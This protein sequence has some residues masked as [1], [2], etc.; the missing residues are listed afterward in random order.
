M[1]LPRPIRDA[2]RP[3]VGRIRVPI[4]SGVNRGRWWSLASAGNGYALGTRDARQMEFFAGLIRPGDCVWDVGAHHG[5]M[6][7]CADRAAGPEGRVYAFEP[8]AR[9]AATLRRHLR[10][11]D[12][13]K[14]MA[15]NIA[16]SD[17]EGTTLFG[18]TGTSKMFAMGGGSETVQV[19]RGAT[20]IEDGRCQ[21]PTVMKIDVEG[22]EAAVLRG[23]GDH[24]PPNARLVVAIHS[25]A[26]FRECCAVLAARG[27][28]VLI[29]PALVECVSGDWD[30]DP[31]LLAL[32]PSSGMSESDPL[33]AG[34]AAG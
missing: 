31:D 8:S 28:H 9:N 15:L 30:G 29:S 18:G 19:T 16:L 4:L 5:Y 27:F 23:L 20:L 21:A 17:F 12:T 33:V 24:L 14:V 1:R 7:L 26:G 13:D 32:G 11:N 25:A 3:L 10:W 34:F 22:A 6:S 2:S